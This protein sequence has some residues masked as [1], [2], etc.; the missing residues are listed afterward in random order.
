[1]LET[2]TQGFRNA[3]LKLQGKTQLSE[4]NISDALKDV[5]ISLLE[6]DVELGVVRTFLSRVHE[7]ALGEVVRTKTKTSGHGLG[8]GTK[9]TP[10]QH[11]IKICHLRK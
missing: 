11:F 7:R 1:M 3:R 8:K 10:A 6:A 9:V 2:L 4:E 5:R